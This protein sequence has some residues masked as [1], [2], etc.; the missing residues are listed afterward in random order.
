MSKEL[1]VGLAVVG[2]AAIVWLTIW[3]ARDVRVGQT[4]ADILFTNV[5]GLA[6]G[7]PVTV[8]GMKAGKVETIQIQD[9]KIKVSVSLPPE[10]KLYRDAAATI[11]MLEL[12]TGKKIEL[13]PGNAASGELAS[14]EMIRGTF[15]ADIP[16]LVGFAGEA[17]DTLRLLI[18][19]IHL[20]LKN[21]NAIL[22]DA[23]LREDLKVSVKNVRRITDDLGTVS[24][25]LR[26][27]NIKDILARVDNTLL[28]VDKLI[29]E[30]QPDLKSA[31]SDVRSTVKNA[32]ALITSLKELTDKLKQD[33]A[34]LAGKVLNDEKFV[35]K[36]DSVISNLNEVLKLGE[37]EGINVRLRVF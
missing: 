37:K 33:R 22:G 16:Q 18:A 12:M 19:D 25:E 23:E 10:L 5:S 30:L 24:R 6:I 28:S 3:W 8:R 7:D 15:A 34:S 9:D 27:A 29:K 13:V 11:T 14:G 1:K 2:A 17:V 36:I 4:Q 31:V 20:T 35:A 32:D 26:Q 21:A